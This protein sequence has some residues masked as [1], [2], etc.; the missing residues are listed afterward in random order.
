MTFNHML[1]KIGESRHPCLDDPDLRGTTEYDVS[2]GLVIYGLIMLK[3]ISFETNLFEAFF[4]SHENG[5]EFCQMPFF[6][7]LRHHMIFILHSITVSHLLICI[8]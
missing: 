7:L 6:N 1:N 3:Y 8:C 5:V 4:K 2:L